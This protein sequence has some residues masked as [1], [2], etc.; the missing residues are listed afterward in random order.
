MIDTMNYGRASQALLI[1]KTVTRRFIAR[2]LKGENGG[3][4]D[5]FAD[6]VLTNLPGPV[7]DRLKERVEGATEDGIIT[8]R[9]S[10]EDRGPELFLEEAHFPRVVGKNWNA[11]RHVLKDRDTV[12]KQLRQIKK[13]RDE[14]AHAN[15]AG[16][17]QD[18]TAIIEACRS[19]VVR[20]DSSAADQLAKLLA[21][22]AVEEDSSGSVA[23]DVQENGEPDVPSM[24]LGSP[25]AKDR[26]ACIGLEDQPNAEG[27]STDSIVRDAQGND[28]ED[29]VWEGVNRF[30]QERQRRV[31]RLDALIQQFEQAGEA[32]DQIAKLKHTLCEL[33]STSDPD[34]DDTWGELNSLRWLYILP[35]LVAEVIEAT[36]G[37][38]VSEDGIVSEAEFEAEGSNKSIGLKISLEVRGWY[39]PH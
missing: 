24:V 7:A 21:P 5:W 25:T 23:D 26:V 20:F 8:N 38:G 1:Y 6:L 12:L 19:V 16:S 22:P 37:F 17:D 29:D 35:E 14:V 36:E 11:F 15:Q 39:G 33:G 10:Q 4:G 30:Q 9:G 3:A 32:Q 34:F 28:G 2:T 18:A 13:Y 31:A 27:E